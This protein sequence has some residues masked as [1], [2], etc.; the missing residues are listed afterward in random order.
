MRHFTAALTAAAALLVA[1]C[2]D[3]GSSQTTDA[4]TTSPSTV[5]STTEVVDSTVAPTTVQPT[6]R[7]T[8]PPNFD[9]RPFEVFVPSGYDAAT[10]APLVI[11]LHGYGV[12]GAIQNFYFNMQPQAEARGFLYVY[13]DGTQNR[14][15]ITSWNATDACCQDGA[16]DDVGYLTFIIDDVSSKYNVDPARIFLVGHSNGGFMSYRMACEAA[17]RI[18]GIVSL[19]G[20]TF[21]DT[22]QCAPSEPVNVLQIHGTDDGT[23]AYEG[24]VTPIGTYPSAETTVAT[25]SA[26]NGCTTTTETLGTIDFNLNVDGVETTMTAFTGCPVDGAVELWTMADSPHIPGLQSTFAADIIDWLFAHPNA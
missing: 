5:S 14:L 13:P 11:L 17:D 19:A 7:P 1:A 21:L 12:T 4:P 16:T 2:S 26:Y 9:D 6:V 24:G 18:A 20:A 23:I 22:A 25:W 15:G 10:A 8:L 3:D